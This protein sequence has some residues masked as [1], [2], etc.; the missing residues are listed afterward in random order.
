MRSVQESTRFV[1]RWIVNADIAKTA[2]PGS[3][4]DLA[5]VGQALVLHF[6]T[7]WHLPPAP[8]LWICVDGGARIEVPVDRHLRIWAGTSGNHIVRVIYKSANQRAH[9]WHE[10]FGSSVEFLGYDAEEAGVLPEREKRKTIEFV[11]DSIT[12]GIL[13]DE[14]VWDGA[15]MLGGPY[16]NDVTAAYAWLTAEALDLEPYIMGYGGVGVTKGGS[17]G[18]P[19]AQK[20]YPFCCAEV[21]VPYESPDY[22]LINHGANDRLRSAEAFCD[23]YR[24]LLDVVT[25]CNPHSQIIVLAPFCG[26]HENALEELVREYHAKQPIFFIPTTNWIPREP[27]HPGREGHRE[28]S[29]RLTEELRKLGI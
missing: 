24:E 14:S 19:C 23:G 6:E 4:F 25:A 1:G 12:E 18:V 17:G 22:V 16:Q 7:R 27:I 10:P 5:F 28:V 26:I 15:K 11:G 9:R 13:V 21:P 20:A 2:A 3:Y 29:R 8:H